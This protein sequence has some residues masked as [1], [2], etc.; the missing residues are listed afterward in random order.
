MINPPATI[1]TP[2]VGIP[3]K[4]PLWKVSPGGDKHYVNSVA[5]SADGTRVVGGTYFNIYHSQEARR[6]P[7][8]GRAPGRAPASPVL[9]YGIY[10]YD[11]S[12]QPLWNNLITASYGVYW[13]AISADRSRAAAGGLNGDTGKGFVRA[14]DA[15]NGNILLDD[16]NDQKR[17]NQVALSG[18]GKWLVSAGDTLRLF[19]YDPGKNCYLQCAQFIGNVQGI[20]NAAISAD[21]RTIVY[22]DYAGHDQGV[23]QPGHIGV[24]SYDGDKLTL[25][26]QFPVPGG[27]DADFCHMIDLAPDGSVFAAGG[28]AGV[29]YYFNVASFI[30]T[31]KPTSSYSTGIKGAVYGV[32]VAQTGDRFV[33]V[34]NKDIPTKDPKQPIELGSACLVSVAASI[35]RLDMTLSLK[36]N[37][38]SAALHGSTGLLAIADGHPDGTPG[39][40]YLYY[41]APGICHLRWIFQTGNMSWPIVISA[42]G[43]AVVGGSD[44][45][46]IYYFTP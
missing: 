36:C 6:A 22:A 42:N 12:G 17:V 18:D 41:Y 45:S 35:A 11:G 46:N 4:Q 27:T 2:S 30:A 5:V 8:P 40:Y 29:F 38:N 9:Q 20:V 13:V 28:A 16:S 34:I 21:G 23:Y 37:P 1:P 7:E 32:A 24:L 10:C 14:Y 15:S 25:R 31:Q 39:H 3:N 26:A 33:G 44:D 43:N 19:Q